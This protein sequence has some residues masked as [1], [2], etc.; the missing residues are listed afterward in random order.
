MAKRIQSRRAVRPTD[1]SRPQGHFFS[2][3]GERSFFQGNGFFSQ[4]L[5]ATSS[6]GP[7]IQAKL[8]DGHDLQAAQF[9]GNFILEATYD[10]ERTVKNW[11]AGRHVGALQQAL[12]DDGQGLPDHGKDGKFGDETQ[13]AVEGYQSKHG[14]FNDPFGQVGAETMAHLDKQNLGGK[15]SPAKPGTPKPGKPHIKLNSLSFLS[16]HGSMKQNDGSWDDAGKTVTNPEWQGGPKPHSLPISQ[17]KGTALKVEAELDVAPASMPATSVKLNG[18]GFA[19]FISFEGSGSIAGGAGQKI[20][21]SAKGS[22]PDFITHFS[23]ENIVWR[24]ETGGHSR[25]I[26]V[27]FGH[28][29]MVTHGTPRSGVT[30]RRVRQAIELTEGFGNKPHD[31]VSAQMDRFPVYVLGKA[32]LGNVWPLAD[33]IPGGAECQ[34]IVRFVEAVND[35]IGLPGKAHGITVYAHPDSPDAPIVG[36]LTQLGGPGMGQYPARWFRGDGSLKAF[37]FDG[38]DNANNYEAALEF[39]HG[40][41]LFYP[42]GTGGAGVKTTKDV[43]HSFAR[44]AWA[45]QDPVKKK[46]VPKRTIKWY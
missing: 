39:E 43:L 29:V 27:S 16:D 36:A 42:G 25:V 38:S 34:A 26:E 22:L 40:A 8:G 32:Y 23:G 6:P 19:P 7:I 20:T 30:T 1:S 37:L 24:L 44:M 33:D 9:A 5:R 12:L 35:A 18:Q 41:K 13:A 31:I 15:P 2:R 28:E 17:T 45:A 21:L 10:G 46:L 14:L 4:G 11:S 3:Q